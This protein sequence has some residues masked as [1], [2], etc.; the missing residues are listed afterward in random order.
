M[1]SCARPPSSVVSAYGDRPDR[2]VAIGHHPHQA[3]AV[4]GRQHP[5][6]ERLHLGSRRCKR[7]VVVNDLDIANFHILVLPAAPPGDPCTWAATALGIP[8]PGR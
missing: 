7:G 2:D 1:L 5:H 8:P 6:I 3:S 4:P